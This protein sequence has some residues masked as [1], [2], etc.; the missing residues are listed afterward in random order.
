MRMVQTCRT[1]VALALLLSSLGCQQRGLTAPTSPDLVS[2]ADHVEDVVEVNGSY[3]ATFEIPQDEFTQIT[4]MAVSTPGTGRPL[5]LP[6]GLR[7]GRPGLEGCDPIMVTHAT[8]AFQ[9]H[10]S[11]VLTRGFYC[12]DV[13]DVGAI[14][15]PVSV[16]VRIVHPIAVG[17]ARPGTVTAASAITVGGSA[18]RSFAATAPGTAVVTLTHLQ[19]SVTT[20]LGLGIQKTDGTGCRV[21]RLI[22][23]TARSS[24][25]FTVPFDPGTYCVQVSDIGSYTQTTSYTLVIQHP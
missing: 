8:P 22:E 6:M 16:L 7:V 3:S 9:A 23:T 18:S 24:P 5:D 2:V 20:G 12:L 19:P 10:Q 15:E 13:F 4:L 1:L 21:T 25:H 14:T 11:L 17:Q